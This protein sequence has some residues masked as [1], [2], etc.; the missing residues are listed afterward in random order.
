MDHF[1]PYKLKIARQMRGLSMEA[2]TRRMGGLVTKQAISKYEQGRIQP[3]ANVLTVLS[4][5]LDVPF[6]YFYKQGIRIDSINFRVD[7]RVPAKSY[8]QMLGIAQDKVEHYLD[9][10]EL[11]A[12]STS[13]T[14]PLKQQLISS[15]EDAESAAVQLRTAWQLGEL[16][17][18]SAYEILESKGVKLV[19]FEAGY[20]HVL[21][22][23]AWINEQIPLVVINQ[24]ANDTTERKR[25]TAFHELGHLF[26]QFPEVVTDSQRERLCNQFAAALLCPASVLLRELGT[27]RKVLTLEELISLRGRYGI[28]IAAA[29]HRAKDLGVI[30]DAYYNNLFNCYIHKN[31]LETG[32]GGY[33]IEEHTDRFDRL[34]CRCVAEGYL[35]SDEAAHYLKKKP[36]ESKRKL[37]LLL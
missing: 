4:T 7:S 36:K 37:T 34:L 1:L 28:S 6:S 26:L 10:E 25:F 33:P 5:A 22:F 32:W 8:E 15:A 23:S 27:S 21:G 12:I 16:P 14:N 30:S 11:L 24:S 31:P 2:L 20:K 19:E 3:T 18:F 13:H 9:I 17:I 29:I 35:T